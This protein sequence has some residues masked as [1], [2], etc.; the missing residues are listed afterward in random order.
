MK[1]Y[2]RATVADCG[3]VVKGTVVRCRYEVLDGAVVKKADGGC[4]CGGRPKVYWS[5]DGGVLELWTKAVVLN[6]KKDIGRP[7]TVTMGDGGKQVLYIKYSV[8]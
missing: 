2:F 1:G 4:S 3:K 8:L 5:C 7:V 6:G